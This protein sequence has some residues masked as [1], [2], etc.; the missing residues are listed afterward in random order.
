VEA[1]A[2]CSDAQLTVALGGRN[3]AAGSSSQ[4]VL[5][6]NIRTAACSLYGYPGVAV[7]NDAGAKVLQASRSITDM[8]GDGNW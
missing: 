2:T 8:T 4:L 5:F 6:R 3:I 1:A 7:L